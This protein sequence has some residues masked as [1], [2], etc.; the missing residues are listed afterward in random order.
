[1][2]R[3]SKM[4]IRRVVIMPKYILGA[5]EWQVALGETHQELRAVNKDS[6][7]RLDITKFYTAHKLEL[8]HFLSHNIEI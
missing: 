4:R 7:Q 6:I 5:K 3:Q 2:T 1:M 8:Q